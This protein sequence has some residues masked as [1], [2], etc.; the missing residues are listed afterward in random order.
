MN[1]NSTLEDNIKKRPLA[2]KE[3]TKKWGSLVMK[4]GFSTIPSLIFQGQRRLGLSPVQLVLLLHMVDFWWK[5]SQMPFPSKTLLAERMGLS[6]RQIQRY[7]TELERAGFIKR[8]ARFSSSNGQQSN[9][10][11]LSGLVGVVSEFGK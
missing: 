4:I 2:E 10:Y 7:L 8:N 6:P 3:S 1:T 11:D 9:E 5:Q